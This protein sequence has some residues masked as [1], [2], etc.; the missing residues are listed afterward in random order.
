MMYLLN[1]IFCMYWISN[2]YLIPDPQTPSADGGFKTQY[3][4]N[5]MS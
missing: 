1:K 3:L 5:S 4:N 2:I